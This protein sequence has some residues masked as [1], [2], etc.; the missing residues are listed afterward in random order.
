MNENYQNMTQQSNITLTMN[1]SALNDPEWHEIMR[2]L[3]QH[4]FK[5]IQQA[6]FEVLRYDPQKELGLVQYIRTDYTN[7]LYIARFI[8]M[9][10]WYQKNIHID[11]LIKY[12]ISVP[13][14]F[15][16]F[17]GF[18]IDEE[19][20]K[21]CSIFEK[22]HQSI[23]QYFKGV[24]R[25][26]KNIN[27]VFFSVLEGLC[28]LEC[29]GL[30]HPGINSRS[31]YK[32]AKRSEGFKVSTPFLYDSFMDE[33]THIY[34]NPINSKHGKKSFNKRKLQEN[35]YN[36]CLLMLSLIVDQPFNSFEMK[37]MKQLNQKKI[38][39]A[40]PKIP[41]NYSSNLKNLITN[42]L[43]HN[44]DV[45]PTP[46][47]LCNA[48]GF[49]PV[50]NSYYNHSAPLYK[51]YTAFKKT[52][53]KRIFD[54]FEVAQVDHPDVNQVYAISKEDLNRS[55]QLGKQHRTKSNFVMPCDYYGK[56]LRPYTGNMRLQQQMPILEPQD[57][58]VNHLQFFDEDNYSEQDKIPVGPSF[59]VPGNTQSQINES[60]IRDQALEK[61]FEATPPQQYQESAFN[62]Q[63]IQSQPEQF[64]QQ[65]YNIEPPVM[66]KKAPQV[67]HAQNQPLE[68]SSQQQEF[69]Q[70]PVRVES[71]QNSQDQEYRP[72][73][74]PAP[75]PVPQ[76]V[77]QAP[78]ETT[79]PY[80]RFSP[81]AFENKKKVRGRSKP[82]SKI[83]IKQAP[84]NAPQTV[85]IKQT[86]ITVPQPMNPTPIT[87]QN[88]YFTNQNPGF[89][90]SSVAS[91]PSQVH[92]SD[93]IGR[94]Y[95]QNN[96]SNNYQPQYQQQE[97]SFERAP[98]QEMSYNPGVYRDVL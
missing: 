96:I 59:K 35:V 8:H 72:I 88:S 43:S 49:S 29:L 87:T 24:S 92:N 1:Q 27:N 22:P 16:E 46:L 26:E 38:Q 31:V 9:V 37:S 97:Q 3:K 58:D 66:Q 55:R 28:G 44:I 17:L 75:L 32:S 94:G 30:H 81:H 69:H 13:E 80:Q 20:G 63:S 47:E 78:I 82:R 68:Q 36:L 12:I 2:K 67:V 15:Q 4:R 91:I 85:V 48:M 50:G 61:S 6:N 71:L 21:V 64:L 74:Q 57:E 42:V 23:E 51:N 62:Q 77:I 98:A 5:D 52:K 76:R 11:D 19:E 93:I 53:K 25:Q 56:T 33:F 14:Q 39:E 65:S 18:Y 70:I 79:S 40:L 60:M 90:N 73:P 34:L 83:R 7:N 45:S 86:P 54:N 89:M 10:N 95:Q 84:I 41:M